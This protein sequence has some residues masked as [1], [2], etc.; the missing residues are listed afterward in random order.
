MPRILGL[1]YGERRLGFAVSDHDGIIAMPLRV[2]EL[3]HETQALEE[4]RRICE[5]TDAEKLVVGLPFNMDGTKGPM[6]VKIESFI[7]QLTQLIS[8]PVEKWDE[9]L[10]TSAA[11]RVLVEADI[12][13]R[14]RKAVR[15]KIAAHVILQGYLDA[16]NLE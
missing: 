11:E 1:D 5:E 15:D 2:V 10:S 16:M 4:V 8:I 9:R 7:K 12:S 3:R 6:A 14:K 13:R